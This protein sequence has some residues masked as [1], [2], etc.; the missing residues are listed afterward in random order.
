MI[1]AAR[2]SR[3]PAT[4]PKPG[5]RLALERFEDRFLPSSSPLPV[6]PLPAAAV[7]LTDAQ[8][9]R[10]DAVIDW[11]ATAL[12]AIWNDATPPTWASRVTAIVAVSVYDAVDAI[13]PVGAPYPVPGL[14]GRPA[15]DASADAAAIAAADTA[16]AALYPDQLALFA[17]EYQATLARVPGGQAQA[18]GI[19]WGQAVAQAVLAWRAN[20]GSGTT[21]PYTPAPPGGPPGVYELTPGAT[22]VLT[23]QWGQV[24]SW[25]VTDPSRFLPP[26]PPA[27]GSVQY[28]ADFNRTKLLG[29][30]TSSAR[31]A[32][33]T[34]YAHF[35]ADVPGHSVT[36]PGHWNEIAEHVSLQR[37]L[38]LA[39]NARLFALLDIGLADA[40]ICCWDAKYLYN[41]W[42]PVTAIT[43]PRASQIN[44]GTTSDP[45]WTPLWKTPNFPSYTSG[46]S[47][48]SGAASTILAHFF[49]DTAFTVG[50]D[51][52]PGYSR[53]FAGFAQA[54]DEAGESR[55]M[56]GIHFEFDNRAGLHVGRELGAYIDQ[57]I[58]PPVSG[59]SVPQAALAASTGGAVTGWQAPPTPTL[60]HAPSAP[61]GA[62]SPG[63][64]G[65]VASTS[66]NPGTSI[67]AS[68]AHGAGTGGTVFTDPTADGWSV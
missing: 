27:L 16:L 66:T 34:L 15:A 47:T 13:R 26:P 6:G 62:R 21:V 8:I 12:K 10:A 5:V 53:S 29:G 20:D 39:Q 65:P 51:D 68:P 14:T 11:N 42:R 18:D 22:S 31:T 2:L 7:G 9:D 63:N 23:P 33:E 4:G 45:T 37:G 54:A 24:T 58:L 59:G 56:G 52:L 17:A 49:G 43:D 57:A 3:R 30:T 40:A 19:A 55:I 38:G 35:W 67:G 41:F 36:P 50:S 32:D 48:F 28:A 60:S 64:P 46:H 1:R 44:P 25:A 61:A